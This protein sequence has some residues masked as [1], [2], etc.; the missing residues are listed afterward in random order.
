ME[1][2]FDSLNDEKITENKENDGKKISGKLELYKRST[3]LFL[4]SSSLNQTLHIFY[5]K[6]T[7]TNKINE[8]LIERK[9]GKQIEE[10]FFFVQ[11]LN[12]N[13]P[14]IN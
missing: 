4:F 12:N 5:E 11:K 10:G 14:L 13:F 7:N 1:K 2:I 8:V 6:E 9:K 3:S